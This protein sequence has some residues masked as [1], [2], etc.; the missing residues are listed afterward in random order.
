MAAF[1]VQ[2]LTGFIT[3]I[4]GAEKLDIQKLVSN[5]QNEWDDFELQRDNN[6]AFSKVLIPEG[7]IGLELEYIFLHQLYQAYV[8][9]IEWERQITKSFLKIP[10]VESIDFL[11]DKENVFLELKISR[12]E[13]ERLET[14]FQ[15]T[16]EKFT[17]LGRE[18]LPNKFTIEDFI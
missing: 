16:K 12:S 11:D 17:Q 14:D 10:D 15:Q 3:Q 9:G 13:E 18:M 7:Y 5:I 6:E 4:P 2:E 8:R 1:T